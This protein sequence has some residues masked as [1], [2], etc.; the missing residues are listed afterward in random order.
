MFQLFRVLGA[1]LKALFVANVALDFESDFAAANAERK[2]ELL[3]QAADYERDGFPE[4]ATEL[5]QR[6]AEI[7]LRKPLASVL[8]SLEHW[9]QHDAV[10]ERGQLGAPTRQPSLPLENRTRLP[11]KRK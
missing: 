4:V 11:K 3:R 8:P 5:R 9:R 1:R 2:A 7:D 10:A 6:A